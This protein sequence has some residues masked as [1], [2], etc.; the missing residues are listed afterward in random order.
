MIIIQGRG[1]MIALLQL[2]I[3]PYNP[4]NHVHNNIFKSVQLP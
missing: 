2:A 4:I 3:D 1:R